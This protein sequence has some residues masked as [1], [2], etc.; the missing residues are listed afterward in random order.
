[1]EKQLKPIPLSNNTYEEENARLK[2]IFYKESNIPMRFK[3]KNLNNLNIPDKEKYIKYLI[4]GS[5]F[6]IMGD[7]GTGK[8]HLAIGLALELFLNKYIKN[9]CEYLTTYKKITFEPAT[10]LFLKLKNS[11]NNLE[12]E[13]DILDKIDSVDL[14]ILDDIGTDKVS[15]WSRQIVYTIVDRRYRN[16][17]QLIIT[18]N[19]SLDEFATRYDDRIASRIVEMGHII[20]L[21]GADRRKESNNI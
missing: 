19:L 14:L 3:N 6:Y 1:M 11:F 8:T 18:S 9:E 4:A 2:R 17:K 15:D 5:S 20:N 12:N 7:V 13:I 21:K 10:E 16:M